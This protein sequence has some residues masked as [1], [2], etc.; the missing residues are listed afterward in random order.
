MFLF[1]HIFQ[2]SPYS[3]KRLDALSFQDGGLEGGPTFIVKF[4]CD[5]SIFLTA[6]P[7]IGLI[8]RMQ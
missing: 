6:Q 1:V 3:L 5:P 4:Y 2:E 8:A 7:C